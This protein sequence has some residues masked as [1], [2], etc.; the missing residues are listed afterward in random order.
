MPKKNLILNSALLLLFSTLIGALYPLI[1]IAELS[2]PPL[3][4]TLLRALLACII[5]LFVVGF[6]M[7]RDLRLIATHWKTF[8]LLGLLLSLFFFSISEAEELITASLSAVLACFL[9]ISTFLITTLIL[10]WEKFTYLRLAGAL[11]ALVGVAVFIG[12]E[13]LLTDQADLPGASLIV[14]G[15]LIYA[16][17]LVV[18]RARELD[19]YVTAAGTMVFVTL[20]MGVAAFVLEQP[21][22]IQPD[23]KAILA[24]VF[25]G[26]FSTGL[27]YVLLYYLVA[28]AGP[29]FTS[30]FGY[31]LPVIAILTSHVLIAEPVGWEKAIGV[32]I[33][34]VGAWM[35]NRVQPEQVVSIR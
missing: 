19:P 1:K 5:L 23:G 22:E 11:I 15:Y 30:T 24:T 7:K 29:V 28:N 26:I 21:L 6:G 25:I 2:I 35:V 8:A 31:F 3:T 34:L 12:F 9:P 20:F 27:A 13:T 16:I 17:H 32:A 14:F 10:R 4:F 18:A 33:T